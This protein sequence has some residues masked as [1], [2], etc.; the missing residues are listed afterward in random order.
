MILYATTHRV[1]DAITTDDII[2]PEWRASDDPAALA[3][4]CLAGVAP[5]V[6]ERA[7]E[8]DVLL[9]G[10]EFG[11]GA[12]PDVAA[13]ALQ[14]AG[15]AAIVCSSADPA[16]VTAAA[17]FGLPVLICS[18]AAAAIAEG[19]VVRL[20]LERGRI[21]DRTSGAVY[22]APPCAPEL[23]AAVRHAQ[24]LARMRRVVEDEGFDG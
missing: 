18:A 9:A 23:L 15:F 16:F 3:A 8:G 7:R 1:G 12:E 4:H 5:V 10:S 24:L 20:D 17:G 19:V 21:E 22:D 6:A 14:A 2:A 11:A 13:L